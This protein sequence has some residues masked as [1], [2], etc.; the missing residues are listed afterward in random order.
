MPLTLSL[1]VVRRFLG[2]SIAAFLAVFALVVVVDLVELLR[3]NAD[4]SAD[5]GTLLLMALLR[6]PSVTIT[7]APFTVLLAAMTC[8]AWYSRTSELVVTRAAGLSVWRL[9]APALVTALCMGVVAFAVYNPVA[10]AFAERF[11]ALEEK[12]FGRS[13]SRLT[14]AGGGIWLRQG[15]VDGQTVIRARR[16]SEGVNQLWRVSV[17]QFGP[18]D[19][20]ERRIEAGRAVL[21]PGQWRLT[22]AQSWTIEPTPVDVEDPGVVRAQT[23]R[24][25][26]LTIPT[27]LT[28]DQI[29]ESFAPPR[30]IAFWDLPGFIALLEESGFSS[31]RHRLHWH[32]LLSAPAVYA[33]MVLFGAAF[34][35]RHARFGGLGSMALGCVLTGFA[36]FFL[37]DVAGAL[38]A[39]GAVPVVLAAWGPPIAAGL[40]ATGLLLHLEDG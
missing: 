3:S 10:A 24:H 11:E 7:A 1:Y 38:G 33:A 26:Q 4:G 12:N 14:V 37:S 30:T 28:A 2:I 34:S 32:S 9:V 15:G 35:M 13:S 25:G 5:F 23:A 20:F 8:F 21:E 31:S 39:S 27:N 29:L 6:A 40:L 22:A 18:N 19:R 16:A 17:F 36:Y